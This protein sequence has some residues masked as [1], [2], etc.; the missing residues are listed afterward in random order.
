M[1]AITLHRPWPSAIFDISHQG[2]FAPK[3]IENRGWR[4]PRGIEGC[5]VAIHAGRTF[6]RQALGKI[7][8][9]V[10]D[11]V[12]LDESDH[13]RGIVG[14][15]LFARQ[16][17]SINTIPDLQKRWFCGPWGWEMDK[18]IALPEP[19]P[20]RGRQGLWN[21]PIPAASRVADQ[22]KSMDTD[23]SLRVLGAIR[24][25]RGAAIATA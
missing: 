23:L 1:K 16:H 24:E 19:V 11:W 14:L 7:Q 20:C 12:S 21:V 5:W 25:Q 22:L 10:G 2:D 6:D 18:A 4:L 17:G 8:A 3:R 15:V 13:P 9:M